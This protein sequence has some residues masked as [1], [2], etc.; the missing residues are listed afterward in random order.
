MNKNRIRLTE[1]QL[2][3][4]IKESVKRVVAENDD[5]QYGYDE[6]NEEDNLTSNEYII[7]SVI[8]GNHRQ[9]RELFDE[10]VM[11]K[12]RAAICDFFDELFSEYPQ[13]ANSVISTLRR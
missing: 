9:A 7:D 6:Y 1:A 13:Y 12:G 11:P 2:H 4:V 8:N 10:N 3:S 5:W